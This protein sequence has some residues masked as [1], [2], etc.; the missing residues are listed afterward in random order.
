[1][2]CTETEKKKKKKNPDRRK[3][4]DYGFM[5]KFYQM[6]KQHQFQKLKKGNTSYVI[7]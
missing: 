4:L 6:F 3:A 5:G 7:L 2:P 1:V